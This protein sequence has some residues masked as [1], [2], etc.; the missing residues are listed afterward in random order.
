MDINNGR[1][2]LL[3]KAEKCSKNTGVLPFIF[4]VLA[5]EEGSYL[6]NRSA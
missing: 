4:L 5:G 6:V 2:I 3:K 1:Y